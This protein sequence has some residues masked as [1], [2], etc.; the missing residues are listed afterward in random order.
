MRRYRPAEAALRKATEGGDVFEDRDFILQR[1]V[2]RRILQRL[3]EAGWVVV[4][5]VTLLER[6]MYRLTE[7][8]RAG[9]AQLD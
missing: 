4:E 6:K 3:V 8:G 9:L 7:R 5:P 2:S 1:G